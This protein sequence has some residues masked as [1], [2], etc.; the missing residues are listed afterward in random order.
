[1]KKFF[2]SDLHFFHHKIITHYGRSQFSSLDEMHQFI[3]D[4]WNK[5]VGKRDLVYVVGDFSFGEKNQTTEV[6][7]S[8][9]GKKILYLGNHDKRSKRHLTTQD[10][11][12]IGFSEVYEEDVLTLSNA[13][14]ILVKHYPYEQSKF[15]GFLRKV[16]GKASNMRT[17][18]YFFPVDKGLYH[19][20]GHFHGGPLM[21]GRQINV[22]AETLKYRP[23]SEGEIC[24]LIN[25]RESK[26]LSNKIRYF[27]KKTLGK[28][29]RYFSTKES[30][31]N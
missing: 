5:V 30:S 12:D 27:I 29:K 16:F 23:I 7:K 18:H 15:R 22:S 21:D 14:P 24:R 8:L 10:F 19:I 13:V 3:I 11:I 2:I 26:K 31:N 28:L 1:M 6:M 9:N 20:H 17:Y 25:D 4:S